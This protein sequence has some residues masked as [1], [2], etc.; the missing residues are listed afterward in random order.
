MK[1]IITYLFIIA[2][3]LVPVA[4]TDLEENPQGILAPESFFKTQADAEAAVMGGYSWIAS[5]YLY[6]RRLLIG[7]QLLSD[8]C[9]IG[10]IGT[11][12][13]RVQ[14]NN[15]QTDGNNGIV[16]TLWPYFYQVIG[17]ANAAIDGIPAVSMDENYKNQLIAE[18]K[19]L[20]ALCYYHLVQ[21]WGDIPYIGA[22][23]SDP[24]QISSISKTPAATIYQHIIADC[25]DGM[26]YLPNTYTN[27]I[28]SR[29]T[30]GTAQTLLASVYLT[31][32]DYGK[33]QQH[34]EDIISNAGTY[35]YGLMEDYQD[36]WRADLGDH[37]EQVWAVDF[38]G[39][40]QGS[41][42]PQNVDFMAPITGVRDADMNG[43]SVVV[44]SPGVYDS[45][46]DRDYR[47]KVSFLTETPV[48]GVMTPY[49]EWRWPRIH[50]AKW[51]LYP[52]AN[53]T[54]DG[55]LSDHNYTIFRYAEVLLIA[56]EAINEAQGGPNASAYAYIN[57]VRA[58]ARNSG[59]TPAAFPAD[60]QPGMSQEA[61]RAAVREERRVELA[62][63]W[64]RWYDLVRWDIAEEAFTGPDSYEPRPN[65]RK[66]HT[67][68][69]L[70]QDELNR[71]PNLLPQ[72]E[73]Y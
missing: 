27:N 53:A 5:E 29:P 36:L 26:Q 16:T 9:D 21:L 52:G 64:K 65:F 71:N 18:A 8:M 47:K 55:T 25:E 14:M 73:G 60:L 35:G 30:R 31:I 54:E 11:A 1:R 19:M 10:D 33:A 59:G 15:F 68:L 51:C 3:A 38:K 13:E 4:C 24:S 56:A 2:T 67:L 72:N 69:P 20:R 17:A 39:S 22:F 66:H 61:F 34:A 58:R 46:D 49:T 28:R 6:G 45:F 63:E 23:V 37:K 7:L 42:Y 12:S 62:F 44:A 41:T 57:A 48:N 70:P 40:V 43:W 32:G 50:I